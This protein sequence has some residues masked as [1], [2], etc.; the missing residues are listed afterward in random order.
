MGSVADVKIVTELMTES[1]DSVL[2]H[3]DTLSARDLEDTIS[4]QSVEVPVQTAA[5]YGTHVFIRI[6]AI[7]TAG[8]LYSVSGGFDFITDSSSTV[9]IGIAKQIRPR[10]EETAQTGTTPAKIEVQ[11]IPNPITSGGELRL[12][13]LAA[14]HTTVG[15]Y[16]MLGRL[17]KELPAFDIADAGEYAVELDLSELLKGVYTVR[18]E[19]GNYLASTR[20]TVV[21]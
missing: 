20:F 21:R 18:V 10:T 19:Q 4:Y 13:M 11:V 5:T 1:G 8:L 9:S 12:R 16:D 6:H 15:I 17:V 14:G 3:S 2:W 7:P